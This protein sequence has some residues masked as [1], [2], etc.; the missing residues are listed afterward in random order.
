MRVPI[1][2]GRNLAVNDVMTDPEIEFVLFID[3]DTEVTANIISRLVDRMDQFPKLAA[4]QPRY[5]I[6]GY[7]YDLMAFL[8]DEEAGFQEGSGAPNK[9]RTPTVE[10]EES[11]QDADGMLWCHAIG[12]SCSLIRTDILRKVGPPWFKTGQHH[13]EDIF[14]YSKLHGALQ[15]VQVAMDMTFT[16]G[17]QLGMGAVFGHNVGYL[18]GKYESLMQVHGSEAMNEHLIYRDDPSLGRV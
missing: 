17:H 3:E 11:L 9:L 13:T 18:R 10:E 6:R 8:P 12:N 15:G 5:Y 2:I 14:F 7:P 1:D 16:C 4:I